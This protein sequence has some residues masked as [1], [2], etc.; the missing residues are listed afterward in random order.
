M[1][2]L[3]I[4]YPFCKKA[5]TYCNF[6]FSTQLKKAYSFTFLMAKELDMRASF[7]KNCPLES[8]YF[9]GGSPSLMDPGELGSFIQDANKRFSF[10]SEIEITVELNPDDVSLDYLQRLKKEAVNRVSLGIQSFRNKDLQL[11]NRVHN[12]DQ[13]RQ[14]LE[15]CLSV[16]E[17]VSVDLIYG[18]PYTNI[19]DWKEN[20]S[21]L[22]QYPIPHIAAYAL[23]VEPKTALAAQVVKGEV[24]LL[25]EEEVVAQYEYLV[26]KTES[27][28]LVNYEFSNFGKPGFFSVNNSN[29]W[30]R[31]PYLGIGPGA[32]SYDGNT[33]RNWNISNNNLYQKAIEQGKLAFE[34]EVLSKKD[35]FNETL[36]T[37]LRTQWGVNRVQ[38]E[39]DFGE[40][41]ARHLEEQCTNH[42][43][44]N[45]LFWDGDTLMVTKQ[46]RFLT[47][48]IAADLFLV[49]LES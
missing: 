31:K 17:N 37:G 41:Y 36:M 39:K 3:Y 16:F 29:Y 35:M 11:M 1:A 25:D 44:Q 4:H 30:K 34:S 43:L 49:A 32:H 26:N 42:I 40:I 24:V 27:K 46:A 2:G 45:N 7:L 20:L 48:G 19:E 22:N 6:H 13:A 5:C 9:G 28:G 23:T 18:M 12:S 21:F 38:I 14:A 10:D 33:I 15:A 47:D 8:I